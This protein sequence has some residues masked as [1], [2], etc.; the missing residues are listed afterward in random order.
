MIATTIFF[1]CVWIF[2]LTW[3]EGGM[4]LVGLFGRE[5]KE[6]NRLKFM[7]KRG[8][9]RCKENP[10][11]WHYPN[12]KPFYFDCKLAKIARDYA[13]EMKKNNHFSHTGPDGSS[14][15]QRCERG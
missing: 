9:I 2:P 13:Y 6:F 7:R 15:W 11:K 4:H 1:A 12:L 14:P 10:V 5:L 8:F 3:A